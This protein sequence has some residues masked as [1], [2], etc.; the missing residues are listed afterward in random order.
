MPLEVNELGIYMR[1][2]DKDAM[3]ARS[4]REGTR[5]EGGGEAGGDDCCGFPKEEIVQDCVARILQI[6]EMKNRR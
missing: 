5:P 1:V 2:T 4:R 6:L 3:P